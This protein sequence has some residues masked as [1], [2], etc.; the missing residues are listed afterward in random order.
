MGGSVEVEWQ[1]TFWCGSQLVAELMWT[2]PTF[3]YLNLI[4]CTEVGEKPWLSWA[5]RGTQAQGPSLQ[6]PLTSPTSPA[7]KVVPRP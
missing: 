6:C 1:V 7:L 4:E 3:L 5:A 2:K